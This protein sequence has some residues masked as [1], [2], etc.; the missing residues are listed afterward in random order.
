MRLTDK[1]KRSAPELFPVMSL[2]K[3]WLT[4]HKLEKFIR[5]LGRQDALL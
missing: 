5:I 3:K 4:R 1:V 2:V